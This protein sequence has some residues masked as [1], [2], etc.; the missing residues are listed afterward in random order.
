MLEH[1]PA[2]DRPPHL[3]WYNIILNVAVLVGYA[4]NEDLGEEVGNLSRREIHDGEDLAAHQLR[5]RVALGE[6]CAGALVAKLG[7]KVHGQLV[8]RLAGGRKRLH[9]ASD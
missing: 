6:L 3:A 4:E 5:C 7:A 2:H 1:I 9:V 8:R